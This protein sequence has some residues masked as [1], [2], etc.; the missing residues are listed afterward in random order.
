VDVIVITEIQQ[1][2][3][4]ELSAIVNDDRVRDPKTQNDILDEIRGLLGANFGQG[5][6]LDQLGKFINRDEQVGQAPGCLLEWSQK[7][8]A[9]HDE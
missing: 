1:F 5:L 6:H 3:S 9:P 7:V 2:F 8:Q 4:G